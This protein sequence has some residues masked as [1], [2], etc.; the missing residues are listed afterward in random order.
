MLLSS[1][2]KKTNEPAP[3][4]GTDEQ[5]EHSH[6][7]ND[8]REHCARARIV[9][10]EAEAV[11]IEN[12]RSRFRLVREKIHLGLGVVLFA[13]LIVAAICLFV[14]GERAGAAYLLGG[15]SG[16]GGIGAVMRR[17]QGG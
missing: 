14:L 10:A 1:D 11:E 6:K 3:P 16:I 12:S 17:T 4:L 9:E 7:F 15:G 2:D 8:A 5:I 13:S